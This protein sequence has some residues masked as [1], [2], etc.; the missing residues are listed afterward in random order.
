[1]HQQRRL[2]VVHVGGIVVGVGDGELDADFA[3]QA[4]GAERGAGAA[5]LIAPDLGALLDPDHVIAPGPGKLR[6]AGL[7]GVGE[8][9]GVQ[10]FLTALALLAGALEDA[11]PGHRQPLAAVE[12]AKLGADRHQSSPSTRGR[13]GRWGRRPDSAACRGSA[14][15]SGCWRGRAAAGSVPVPRPRCG[16]AWRRSAADRAAAAAGPAGRRRKPRRRGRPGE[17]ASRR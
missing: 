15:W 10:R 16:R 8:D 1:M 11:R 12:V 3:G 6:I 5:V 9:P 7:P 17:K 13:G 14:R 4:L 2:R